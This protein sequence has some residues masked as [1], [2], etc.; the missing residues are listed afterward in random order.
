M[1]QGSSMIGE[2]D[3]EMMN[4]VEVARMNE[5]LKVMGLTEAQ[6]ITVQNYIATGVGLPK[7]EPDEK[8]SN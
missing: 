1:E 3:V 5:C 8:E 6:I 4:V 2:E 7:Q